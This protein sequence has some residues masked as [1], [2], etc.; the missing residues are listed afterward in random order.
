M[1]IKSTVFK[2]LAFTFAAS[3]FSFAALANSASKFLG[4]IPVFGEIPEDFGSY[5]NQI[6]AENGCVWGYVE[7]TRGEY[8]W[9]GCDL[10]YNWA[11]KNHAHFTFHTLLW[12]SQNPQWL[13][14]L[15]V[16]ETKK[17][18][19]DWIDA[20]KER[21]LDLEMIEV[22]NEAV[23][24]GNNYHSSFSSNK[25]IEA[26]G[27][28]SGNY[29][30]VVTAFKMAR[31]RWPEA[32][33]IYN[34]YNTIQWQKVEGIDLLK[35]IKAQGAPV[36]AYGMQFHETTAQG[37]GNYCLN[38][39]LL[40]R[41]LYEAHEQTGLPIY[42]TQYDVG[43]IDDEFQKKCYQ[44][45]LPILMETDY[46]AG[47]TLWGYIYGKT[48]LSCNGL[49][50]GCSGL[51]KDG[52]E[53]PALTWLKEYFKNPNA[54]YGRG[55]ADGATKFFGNMIADKQEIPEDFQTYW[56]QVSP[57]NACTWTVIE[58]VRGEYDWSG[59]DR[60]YYW[61]QKNNVKFNF[62]SLLWGTH[63]PSWLNNLDIDETKKAVENWFDKAAMRYPAP[64]MIEVV[65]G[66]SRDSYGHYHSGF[67]SGNKII[68]ALGGD[69]DDYKFIAT[70]FKMA[71]KRWPY[72]T[73]IYNDV[74]A[75]VWQNNLGA[76]VIQKIKAQHAPVD[77]YGL[78]A[79]N[80]TFQGTGN[81][82]CMTA[83]K[84]KK[85][86]EEIYEQTKLPLFI[87]EYSVNTGNDSLKKACYSEQIPVFMES[88]YI[89][90]V[91]IGGYIYEIGGWDESANPGLIKDGKDLPAMTWLKD[92]FKEHFY[93]AKNMWYSRSIPINPLDS[94]DSIALENPIAIHS[95][96]RLEQN[97]LQNY[98][99]F[100]VQGVR[101]GKLSAYDF[102]DAAKSLR[103][104]SA[105]KSSGI[106]FLRNR[107]TGK[108][109]SVG[110]VK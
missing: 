47:I 6:T 8:D 32:I 33:L 108:M 63:T 25:L 110:V 109:Q 60:I 89:A 57:E 94:L 88:E 92:Y 106:Y 2:A 54:R 79:Y 101:L 84:I 104:S 50:Q 44:E 38:T 74:N 11:K 61:A 5:W 107:S 85:G 95:K 15:D 19:T 1:S 67:G 86:I 98:D 96:I 37:T 45:H 28:D 64:Y 90:G 100:D 10:A 13:R 81:Q 65:N 69:N 80:Q 12:G 58:K 34:D 59:C 14:E 52:I 29:E 16:D 30:F 40:K 102:S 21:Y 17:A 35:K 36:D 20:V 26:L 42:I 55:L 99:V 78:T 87:S 56:N 24:S 76:E 27:G 75:N 22:V 83:A 70:A 7:K 53:R 46:V 105:A 31:E 73:L 18:W 48:W 3:T 97:T 103:T 72:A 93:D 39:S 77:A 9:T 71:R 41:S 23:K 82:S 62:R 49:E 66:G 68:E 43:S 51:I 91:T 4:N